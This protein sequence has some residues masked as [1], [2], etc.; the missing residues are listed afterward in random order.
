MTTASQVMNLISILILLAMA[1]ACLFRGDTC[2]IRG[3]RPAMSD[4]RFIVVDEHDPD[5]SHAFCLRCG[6]EIPV[7]SLPEPAAV[8][9]RVVTPPAIFTLRD[10]RPYKEG[11]RCR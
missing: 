5:E 3:H 9:G 10:E 1:V 4:G 8:G 11:P 2:L 6:M 7:F